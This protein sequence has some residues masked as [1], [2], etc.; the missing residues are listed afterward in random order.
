M[1]KI[2]HQ[3][4]GLAISKVRELNVANELKKKEPG[5]Y[6]LSNKP[7]YISQLANADKNKIVSFY[8]II[9]DKEAVNRF[10]A[11]DVKE[12][13]WW[14]W[15]SCG[16]AALQMVLKA[17]LGNK[18][19][20]TTMDLVREGLEIDGYD[21]VNDSG[22]YHSALLKIAQKY[23]FSGYL[24]K[25]TPV[26]QIPLLIDQDK[27]V[28]CSVKSETGGHIMLATGYKI[29]EKGMLSGLWFNDPSNYYHKGNDRYISK[30]DFEKIYTRRVIVI[31]KN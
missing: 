23:G 21:E 28:L 1:A 25:F 4:V 12:F 10:G 15:R 20:K 26:S 9:N 30:K 13:S 2:F 17:E 31:N 3:T 16:I 27:Y 5:D 29:E 11:K 19:N 6:F 7:S 22:W 8:G 24:A 14:S 18:F